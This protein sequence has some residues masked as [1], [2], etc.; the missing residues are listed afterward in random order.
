MKIKI[1]IELDTI[2]DREEIEELMALIEA[3]RNKEYDEE[4]DD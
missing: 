2:R 1:E 3:I 4:Y